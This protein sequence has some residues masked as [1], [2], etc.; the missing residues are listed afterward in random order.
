MEDTISLS[1]NVKEILIKE[2]QKDGSSVVKRF[3]NTGRS[4]KTGWM[5]LYVYEK[6][7]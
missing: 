4:F 5:V 6:E 2:Q 1:Q 7:K 3:L